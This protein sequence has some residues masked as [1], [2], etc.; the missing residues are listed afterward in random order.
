M[1]EVLGLPDARVKGKEVEGAGQAEGVFN[2]F[3]AADVIEKIDHDLLHAVTGEVPEFQAVEINL[4]GFGDLEEGADFYRVD[5][6]AMERV[7]QAGVD[8]EIR[9]EQEGLGLGELALAEEV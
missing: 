4:V 9:S 1:P 3:G 6:V 8:G 2:A 5:G 7:A